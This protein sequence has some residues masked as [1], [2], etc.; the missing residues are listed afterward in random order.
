MRLLC[1]F[2]VYNILSHTNVPLFAKCNFFNCLVPN[3]IQ[4]ILAH[5]IIS[6]WP[7]VDAAKG[8]SCASIPTTCTRDISG[9]TIHLKHFL[10]QY[11]FLLLVQ[12]NPVSFRFTSKKKE[13]L[14]FF[15]CFCFRKFFPISLFS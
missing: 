11:K 6:Y 10:A 15:L 12:M 9:N 14:F 13:I 8:S 7:L 1:I 4:F 2:V 3:K 5:L